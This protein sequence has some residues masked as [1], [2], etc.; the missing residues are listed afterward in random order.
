MVAT[1][2]GEVTDIMVKSEIIYSVNEKMNEN[3]DYTQ[4]DHNYFE[5]KLKCSFSTPEIIE[6]NVFPSGNQCLMN[7]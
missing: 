6:L 4:M 1:A 7:K 2:D 5:F 3:K